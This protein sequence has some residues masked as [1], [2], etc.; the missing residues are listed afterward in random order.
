M[1]DLSTSLNIQINEFRDNP[2]AY[3][4]SVIFV[5]VIPVIFCIFWY[6]VVLVPLSQ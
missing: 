5:I 4:I 6:N 3:I 1:M 2:I